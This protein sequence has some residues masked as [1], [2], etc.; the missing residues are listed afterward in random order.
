MNAQ[1]HLKPS[2]RN[3]R[4]DE[5]LFLG[6]GLDVHRR[7][8]RTIRSLDGRG[9]HNKRQ[10]GRKKRK[11]KHGGHR[12]GANAIDQSRQKDAGHK[13]AAVRQKREYLD[14]I[15][16]D[17]SDLGYEEPLIYSSMDLNVESNGGGDSALEK[18][19]SVKDKEAEKYVSQG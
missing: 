11:R 17:A 18:K 9:R 15:F 3:F 13:A 7:G 2:N 5:Q 12:K 10:R 19:E 14:Q 8:R 4:A 6:D 16:W 1:N